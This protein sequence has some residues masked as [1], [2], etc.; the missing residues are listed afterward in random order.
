[1]DKLSLLSGRSYLGNLLYDTMPEERTSLV[2]RSFQIVG[3]I[4]GFLPVGGKVSLKGV[5]DRSLCLPL[6]A[7]NPADDVVFGPAPSTF[8][9]ASV[10]GMIRM[11]IPAPPELMMGRFLQI[12]LRHTAS[13]HSKRNETS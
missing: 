2:W 3:E 13:L 1:M 7:N 4:V 11:A 5:N 6:I 10:L 12:G 8:L 9:P